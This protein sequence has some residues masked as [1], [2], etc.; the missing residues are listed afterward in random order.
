MF[1]W[2]SLE[3]TDAWFFDSVS[4]IF[5][6]DMWYAAPPQRVWESVA[7]DASVPVCG[8]SVNKMMVFRRSTAAAPPVRS[9]LL[10]KLQVHERF[11]RWVS[12]GLT[13]VT[14]PVVAVLVIVTTK[15]SIFA[16]GEGGFGGERAVYI[17]GAAESSAGFE[18]SIPVSQRQALL[19]RMCGDRNPLRQ[20][21]FRAP[22]LYG[23]C[24]HVMM[25]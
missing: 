15:G 22:S 25:C 5:R 19:H 14:V 11:I 13:F 16:R 2:H 18:L 4:H 23:L 6:Y 12:R 7:S 3:L 21:A 1:R 17:V 9:F 10:G 8:A 20:Q 24:A